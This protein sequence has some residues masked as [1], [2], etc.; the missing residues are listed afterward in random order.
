[1]IFFF[2]WCVSFLHLSHGSISGLKM[3]TISFLYSILYLSYETNEWCEDALTCPK[4]LGGV[5]FLL[6]S[7]GCSSS[8]MK[9][10]YPVISVELQLTLQ[11]PS[12]S[13]SIHFLH[14]S[15]C[16]KFFHQVRH[17]VEQV[18]KLRQVYKVA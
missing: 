11:F 2:S 5:K 10:V 8:L 9:M 12:Y 14:H 13:S 3:N 6:I 18:L 15:F 17:F 4:D 7:D 1:L 16:M